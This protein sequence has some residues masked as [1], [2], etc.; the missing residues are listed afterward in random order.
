M[1]PRALYA[2]V[3]DA[4]AE[5][6][7][8]DA[9]MLH[10]LEGFI[11]AGG[12]TRTLSEQ[13]LSHCE[14]TA[15]A[16]FDVDQLLDYRSRRPSM[17]F[18]TNRWADATIP[19]LTLHRVL[20]ASG[21][22]FLLLAGPE[23]DSQWGRAIE[24]VLLVA[25][26]LG[27]SQLVTAGAVPMGVPHTKPVLVTTHGTRKE[28]VGHN[29]VFIDRI[30]VPGSFSALLELR[31]GERGLAARG[32]VAHVPHYLAQ[33][34]FAPAVLR[35]ARLLSDAGVALHVSEL[36]EMASATLNALTDELAGDQELSQLVTG[37]EETY[38]AMESTGEQ[39]PTAEEIGRAAERFL[40]DY[41]EKRGEA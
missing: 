23:P 16:E 32:F 15:V 17:T 10:L 39:V 20:D 4:W 30:T 6:R 24:A 3:P 21:R 11:D 12:V 35:L 19:T 31:A 5:V 37:L 36:E 25:A 9:V 28:L 1:D 29:P 33:G 18:D 27:V 7:G 14:H 40:A 34:V 38:E 13:I 22:P 26:E 2:P 8:T 41:D